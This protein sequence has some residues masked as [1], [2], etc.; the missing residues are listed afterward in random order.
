MNIS[1]PSDLEQFVSLV[2]SSGKYKSASDVV[3]DGL[4]LLKD[5]EQ[6]AGQMRQKVSVGIKQAEKEDLAPPKM[7]EI[8]PEAQVRLPPN[9]PQG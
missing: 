9:H 3:C 1:L 6:R 7:Q 2:I 8:L 5:R 4:L